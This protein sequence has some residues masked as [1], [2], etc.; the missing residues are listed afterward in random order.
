MQLEE[1]LSPNSI[2]PRTCEE[3]RDMTL[4]RDPLVSSVLQQRGLSSPQ[5]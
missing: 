4:E 2:L 5:P 1:L 3:R